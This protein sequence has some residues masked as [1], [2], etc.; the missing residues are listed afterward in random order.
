[1]SLKAT[2]EVLNLEI[3]GV[4]LTFKKRVCVKMI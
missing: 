2:P 4:K 3:G 1:M